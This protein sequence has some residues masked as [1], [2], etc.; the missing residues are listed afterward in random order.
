MKD[1]EGWIDAWKGMLIFLVVFGHVIGGI[2]YYVGSGAF[3]VLDHLYTAI[4]LF[5]M[6][7]FFLLAGV[8]SSLKFKSLKFK[9]Q[10][11][12]CDGSQGKSFAL[13]KF[14][15]LMVPYFVW[16]FGSAAVFVVASGFADVLFKGVTNGPYAGL[17]FDGP[18]WQPFVSILH[19][20]GWPEGRGFLCNSVLWFLPCMF[21]V[22]MLA[23][24]L[25][26]KVQGLRFLL[27]VLCIVLAGIVNLQG[28][29]NWPWCMDRV[30]YYLGFFFVGEWMADLALRLKAVR[31]LLPRC[32]LIAV[33][34]GVYGALAWRYPNLNYVCRSWGWYGI[35]VAMAVAG[36][37]LSMGTAQL[38][39]RMGGWKGLER[40][41]VASLGVMLCHKFIVLQ[42][43]CGY[44]WILPAD[45]WGVSLAW[46][47]GLSVMI[48]W[49]AKEIALLFGRVLPWSVGE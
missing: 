27:A 33:G 44:T 2:R 22:L 9:V 36:S 23:Q 14:R 8:I 11:L 1:R 6:P 31:T 15:R 30:P 42:V 7:A 24:G 38:I 25:R 48:A 12:K 32:A 49:I 28:W 21:V 40:L 13:R 4:Y 17:H 16:G 5:H 34:W 20:G 10:G 3:G 26:F 29:R 47:V 39:G 19:A 37:V 45:N 35:S 46:G 43:Q 41:G 18:W